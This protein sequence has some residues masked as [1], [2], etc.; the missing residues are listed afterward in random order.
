MKKVRFM[1]ILRS[2]PAIRAGMWILM[3]TLISAVL[4]AFLE[5]TVNPQFRSFGDSVWWVFVT[6]STVGYGDK[7]PETTAGRLIAVTIML[8]G[9][10]L[11]SVITATISSV[12]VARKIREGKGLEEIKFKDHLLICGWNAQGE[13][14]LDTLERET[15]GRRPV[16]LVN[17]L[18]E[19]EVADLLGRFNKLQIRFVRGDYTRE[20]ILK[21]ANIKSA[22]AAIVLPDNS[23]PAIPASDERTILATLSLKALNPNLKVYAHVLDKENISHLKKAK[24]DEVIISDAYSG[25]LLANHVMS[26]GIPQL[27]EQLFSEKSPYTVRRRLIPASLVGKTYRDLEEFYM[28]EHSGIL[29]G[30]GHVA[31]PI[32]ISELMSDDYSYLDAFIKRKFEESGRGLDGSNEQV[33]VVVNPPKEQVIQKDD[34]YLSIERK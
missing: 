14:I 30:L 33:K 13:Q 16:V 22:S 28:K 12:F 27:F 8:L 25:Y 20:N 23:S 18:S 26:P 29:L 17:H 24:A 2:N 21:R 34:F 5:G 19:D 32:K 1:E 9:I 7:V 6:I 15:A 4:I 31:E 10:A 3:I 11:L